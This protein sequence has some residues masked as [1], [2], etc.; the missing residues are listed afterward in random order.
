[1]NLNLSTKTQIDQ[2][3]PSERKTS[4]RFSVVEILFLIFAFGLF[5]WF[6]IIPKNKALSTAVGRLEIAK[7]EQKK[8]E[9][10]LKSLE[11]S[12]KVL[13]EHQV[14]IAN[15]DEA[16][17]LDSRS[18]KLYILFDS[19]AQSSGVTVGEISI[20]DKGETVY[21]NNKD[22]ENNPFKVKRNLKK[23]SGSIY[24]LGSYEQL[25]AFL[26]QLEQSGRITNVVGI[27]IGRE[28]ESKLSLR[29]TIEAYSYE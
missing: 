5:C 15:L 12:V 26:N 25:Q 29:A 8:A 17:P 14:D 3:F 2:S 27:E 28:Q 6:V 1:M 21:A 19:L 22:L 11:D 13:G 9:S 7:E 23:F 4:M 16:L 24:V 10:N 20:V 18:T